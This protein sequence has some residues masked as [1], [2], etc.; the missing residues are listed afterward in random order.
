VSETIDV[1][2]HGVIAAAGLDHPL[3]GIIAGDWAGSDDAAQLVDVEDPATA[4]PVA[5]FKVSSPAQVDDAV[6]DAAEVQIGLQ[7]GEGSLCCWLPQPTILFDASHL[8]RRT[9]VHMAGSARLLAVEMLIWGRTAMGEDVRHGALRDRW[10]VTRDG[11]LAFADTTRVG[12]AVGDVLDRSATLDGARVTAM[13]LY[14]APDAHRQLDDVRALLEHASSSAGAS[15][16][17]GML[18]VRAAAPDG[19]ELQH[20]LQP[21][22]VR[23]GGRPL[24]RVWQC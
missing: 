9:H 19:R 14:V 16:W 15:S 18:L 5:A 21:V 24:P 12:G 6:R 7:L 11:R 1:D 13:L 23:L 3:R 4:T 17:N 8:D 2:A 20:D 22:I 10:R